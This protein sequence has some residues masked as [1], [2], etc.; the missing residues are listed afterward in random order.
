MRLLFDVFREDDGGEKKDGGDEHDVARG[1]GGFAGAVGSCIP[2]EDV[3][4]NK[5]GDTH[6]DDWYGG[7]AEFG[8]DFCER[9][10]RNPLVEPEASE[11]PEHDDG[12]DK[13][14]VCN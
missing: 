9:F 13:Y 10:A 1:E 7:P 12:R 11:K 3:V 4:E 6:E 2:D 8:V 5:V 14:D